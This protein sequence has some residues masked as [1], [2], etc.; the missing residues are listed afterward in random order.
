MEYL[1]LSLREA[2]DQV[3]MERLEKVRRGLGGLCAL[4]REGNMEFSF[5]TRGMYRGW[6]NENGLIQVAIY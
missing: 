5:N 3:V 2:T 1:G 6:V 4:D